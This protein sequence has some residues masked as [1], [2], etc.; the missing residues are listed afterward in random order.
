MKDDDDAEERSLREVCPVPRT[1]RHDSEP[2][3]D[4]DED[5]DAD[6]S[7]VHQ[8]AKNGSLHD[9]AVGKKTVHS[10]FDGI[11]DDTTDELYTN[12]QTS[13]CVRW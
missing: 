1:G 13:E 10:P 4:G 12:A 2:E 11:S 6:G 9:G 5:D 3:Y 8:D 7:H